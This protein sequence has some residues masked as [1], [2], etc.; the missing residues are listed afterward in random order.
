MPPPLS[1]SSDIRVQLLLSSCIKPKCVPSVDWAL[2]CGVAQIDETLTLFLAQKLHSSKASK[3]AS[4][5]VVFYCRRRC[6]LN[7]FSHAGALHQLD[8]LQRGYSS[9]IAATATS[10]EEMSSSFLAK[11]D[12][13]PV[14]LHDCY[15]G[16]SGMQRRTFADLPITAAV[17]MSRRY[18]TR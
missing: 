13:L 4:V 1:Y 5:E 3:L 11:R 18:R 6:P 17:V 8:Q 16:R 10:V 2:F 14:S 12:P 9:S 15:A 7:V